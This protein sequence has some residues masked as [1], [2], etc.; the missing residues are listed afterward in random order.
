MGESGHGLTWFSYKYH[1]A[2]QSQND[3][4]ADSIVQEPI[5]IICSSICRT[6]PGDAHVHDISTQQE[7]HEGDRPA[8]GARP[9]GQ[10]REARL[11]HGAEDQ[12]PARTARMGEGEVLLPE[13]QGFVSLKTH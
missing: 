12:N 5:L 10:E 2:Q 4:A 9:P 3:L 1:G 11:H 7:R 6:F 8:D 13:M